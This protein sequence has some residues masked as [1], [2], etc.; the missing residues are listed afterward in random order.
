MASLVKY[1][2]RLRNRYCDGLLQKDCQSCT[3]KLHRSVNFHLCKLLRYCLY[4]YVHIPFYSP[5]R[6]IT[7]SL[8]ILGIDGPLLFRKVRTSLIEFYSQ[9]KS[10][11]S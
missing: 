4:L 7:Y 9:I 11:T 5:H 2:H 6:D 1:R 3:N 8:G 10:Q